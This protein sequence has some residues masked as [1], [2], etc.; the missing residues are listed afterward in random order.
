MCVCVYVHVY[1]Y[2]YTDKMLIKR[3]DVIARNTWRDVVANICVSPCNFVARVD[4]VRKKRGISCTKIFL[5]RQ[6]C[7]LFRDENLRILEFKN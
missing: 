6:S 4:K 3:R 5:I 7:S 2:V 1:T